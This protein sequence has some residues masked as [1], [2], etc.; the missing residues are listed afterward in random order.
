MRR[1]H[2]TVNEHCMIYVC[3]LPHKVEL[4]QIQP[5]APIARTIV[6][7]QVGLM[8]VQIKCN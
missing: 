4:L 7:N 6:Y 1:T 8:C 5:I 3:E 2:G